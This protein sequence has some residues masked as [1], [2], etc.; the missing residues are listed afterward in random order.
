MDNIPIDLE[1]ILE[2]ASKW[3]FAG[4]YSLL[5]W[6]NQISQDL[7]TRATKTTDTLEKL[8]NN[9][10]STN[11]ALDNVANSLTTLQFGNQFVEC[12]V[13]DDDETITNTNE[14]SSDSQIETE[15]TLSSKEMLEIFLEN[16]LKVLRNCHERY[17][18]D[19]DDSD[20]DDEGKSKEKT[21]I[22]QPINPYNEKPL[23]FIYG[24]KDWHAKWHVGL[25]ENQEE[26]SYSGDE[27][28]EA[29]SESSSHTSTH[30]D[31]NE[32]FE[33]NTEWASSYSVDNE[34]FNTNI[35]VKNASSLRG[36]QSLY[37]GTK[38]IPI[39]AAKNKSTVSETS[40]LS[41]PSSS[42]AKNSAKNLKHNEILSQP[43]ESGNS[44]NSR[45]V[46]KLIAKEVK[47]NTSQYNI[48]T[49]KV[50]DLFAEPNENMESI[51]SSS[52]PSIPHKIQSE[53][54]KHIV[55]AG[56]PSTFTTQ[57]PAFVDLFA[58]PPEDIP[59]STTSSISSGQNIKR[60]TVNLFDDDDDQDI[61][62]KDDFLSVL[63]TTKNEEMVKAKNEEL[64]NLS[65]PKENIITKTP[66][67]LFEDSDE[68][69]DDFLKA[70]VKKSSSKEVTKTSLTKSLLFDDEFNDYSSNKNKIS[71]DKT[72]D[73]KDLIKKSENIFNDPENN[74][75]DVLVRNIAKNE[76]NLTMLIE[77]NSKLTKDANVLDTDIEKVNT[78]K[79]VNIFDDLDEESI[80]NNLPQKEKPKKINLFDDLDYDDGDDIF[81]IKP[82]QS[83]KNQTINEKK[84]LK[85]NVT[86]PNDIDE[87]KDIK[88]ATK[89]L[90][91]EE[92]VEKSLT[93]INNKQNKLTSS[94]E[95]VNKS[96]E[97]KIQHAVFDRNDK[98]N[99]AQDIAHKDMNIALQEDN[100]LEDTV[101][102]ENKN[103]KITAKDT[104]SVEHH[105]E[106]LITKENILYQKGFN[107]N[108]N[109]STSQDKSDPVS[110]NDI[111]KTNTTNK[112]DFNSILFLDEP[113]EDD[114][115]FFEALTK[116]PQTLNTNYNTIDL[117]HDIYEP[118]L[119][120]VPI[121][122]ISNNQKEVV[123]NK[124][125]SL[126]TG[127]QLFSDIPPDDDD[128]NASNVALDNNQTKRLHSVFYD[129]FNETLMAL[130]NKQIDKEIPKH[131][132]FS[133]EPP[134]INEEDTLDHKLSEV[135]PKVTKDEAKHKGSDIV[136]KLQESLSN[137]EN[138][139]AIITVKRPVS[140]LQMPHI[141]IN[142]QALLPGANTTL[143]KVKEDNVTPNIDEMA[144]SKEKTNTI[145]CTKSTTV[146]KESFVEVPRTAETEHILPSVTKNR[147]RAPAARRPSTRRAR[148][149]NYRKS[150]IEEQQLL[151]D[152]DTNKE[153]HNYNKELFKTV[154]T[155]I[156]KIS[157]EKEKNNTESYK[158]EKP[159]KSLTSKLVEDK[160]Q[161][162]TNIF[163]PTNSTTKEKEKAKTD[164]EQI[165]SNSEKIQNVEIPTQT[166]VKKS[167]LLFDEDDDD[168]DD[169]F[170][171][172]KSSKTNNNK[173]P[174]H[175][176]KTE[177]KLSI[178][179]T[180]GNNENNLLK[181]TNIK[182]T[183]DI[184]N[185]VPSN[186]I[187][188]LSNLVNAP[189]KTSDSLSNKIQ[190]NPINT[191]ETKTTQQLPANKTKSSF[192]D[193][194]ED[195][196]DDLFKTTIQKPINY[197]ISK[198]DEDFQVAGLPTISTSST[199]PPQKT[200]SSIKT[201]T[202][203][204][205]SQKSATSKLFN[206]SDSDSD[207]L[208][209]KLSTSKTS[210]NKV[211]NQTTTAAQNK[212]L[213][214]TSL[215]SDVSDEED[216]LKPASKIIKN[217]ES[218]K[219]SKENNTKQNTETNAS[220]FS[221]IDS[222]EDD[223]F[224]SGSSKVNT[225]NV[226]KNPTVK[227]P[228]TTFKTN[229]AI[230]TEMPKPKAEAADNPLADLL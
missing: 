197:N 164:T 218:K 2:Q 156:P 141:N 56:R 174:N 100:D 92:V 71:F 117:E 31:D 16:N 46:S 37:P 123:E 66:K 170:K 40:S 90:Q 88:N 118:E 23:P 96:R 162:I 39:N 191:I 21:C 171:H 181:N 26:N 195:D 62:A 29:F 6:M 5:Q 119:P 125:T 79:T 223:L 169:L 208:F 134:P 220:L 73:E 153:I 207:D 52:S 158:E 74:K 196:D 59:S 130:N 50:V 198:T 144:S 20:E 229:T 72:L 70:F 41:T 82:K 104:I 63:T 157:Q 150:L 45:N 133:D 132:I 57:P 48:Q 142:V 126:Y 189:L 137:K 12:R 53:I 113:P 187:S 215:F 182:V 135:E 98:N 192:L 64:N 55:N 115:E 43:S 221:D 149:E 60:K 146:E 129:D 8:N 32:S 139:E 42:M 77:D 166:A 155:N 78:K 212:K 178:Q 154:S 147:V 179:T 101:Q 65:P 54:N 205:T 85:E 222:D 17:S 193:D 22:Y 206:D 226:A 67:S 188:P 19:L 209:G 161:N 107:N 3:T 30:L 152:N 1:N 173:P 27:I 84:L 143:R 228:P 86:K 108:E 136:S 159:T 7:E 180:K 214:Q 103:E 199:T 95:G 185:T 51:T 75:N 49:P 124:Q 69:D 14:A 183:N 165:I 148:Q 200:S 116:N 109:L 114:N 194:N 120:K 219:L 217:P 112:Y 34:N 163:E 121:A 36:S 210:S 102:K 76:E 99:S 18:I 89:E 203:E 111:Q 44:I 122:N 216:F 13:Q 87:I 106:S 80:V 68:E 33:S 83:N 93:N 110:I 145:I 25:Y 175:V 138:N 47:D 167:C 91:S 204:E 177:P 190:E 10:R 97:T 81:S 202:A 211:L 9:I 61:N 11:I 4:D 105:L 131:S 28:S 128:N 186:I 168:D 35:E 230:K 94:I 176:N 213:P 24:S 140:K 225:K 201:L 151:Q 127:L 184:P 172:I 58:E 160:S 227:M 15:N 224:G 38:S